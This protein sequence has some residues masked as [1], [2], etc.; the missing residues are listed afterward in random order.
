MMKRIV[1]W[2]KGDG[3]FWVRVFG[4][5]CSVEDRRVRAPLFSERQGIDKPLRIGPF[6]VKLLG[7]E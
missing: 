6:R 2:Y 1:Y 5:G 7:G 3:I 4:R